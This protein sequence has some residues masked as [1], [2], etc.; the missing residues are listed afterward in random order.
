MLTLQKNINALIIY[1][2]SGVLLGAFGVQFIW[3]ETPCPLCLLQRIGM[4]SVAASLA[5]NIKFGIRTFHY[6]LALLS[7]FFGGFVALRQISLHVCP[8]FPE[9]G[10]PVLGISLYTWSFFVFVCCVL[11]VALLLFLY[12]DREIP[13]IETERSI[14]RF[15]AISFWLIFLVA[16]F[17]VIATFAQCGL[18]VCE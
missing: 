5:L 10:L 9:F 1:T 11:A 18:G 12:N 6:G 4:I 2:I 3:H 14:N 16:F 8:G 15:Q 7:S 13:E 17:N